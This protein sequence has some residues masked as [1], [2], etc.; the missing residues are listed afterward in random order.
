AVALD[1]QTLPTLTVR[2]DGEV[3]PAGKGGDSNAPAQS[4]LP[5]SD[6]YGDIQVVTDDIELWMGDQSNLQIEIASGAV[7]K[8]GGSLSFQPDAF[9][10]AGTRG[11]L[12]LQGLADIGQAA[13]LAVVGQI[14]FD[15][16]GFAGKRILQKQRQLYLYVAPTAGSEVIIV[17]LT[18]AA[19]P[20]SAA[21]KDALKELGEILLAIELAAA[22]RV[23]LPAGRRFEGAA[24]SMLAQLVVFGP[25][26]LVG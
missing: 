1:A 22:A 7:A 12:H 16:A 4:R 9:A 26:C 15:R 24:A 6:R 18:A 11:N 2:G 8:A 23:R 3:D 21:A 20:E 5:G 19:L 13:V 25:F 17:E 10:I 14:V